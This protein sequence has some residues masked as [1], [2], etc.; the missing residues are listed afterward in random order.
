MKGSI[1]SVEIWSV[2]KDP[3]DPVNKE[4]CSKTIV[5]I[6]LVFPFFYAILKN[7]SLIQRQPELMWWKEKVDLQW[8]LKTKSA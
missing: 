2:I 4:Y 5:L 3:P 7:V 1:E 8:Q 6:Y